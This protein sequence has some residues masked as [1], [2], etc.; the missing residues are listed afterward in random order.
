VGRC[1]APSPWALIAAG[2]GAFA[3]SWIVGF[4]WA[5][6]ILDDAVDR[7]ALAPALGVAVLTVAGIAVDRAGLRLSSDVAM[8]ATLLATVAGYLAASAAGYA[9]VSTRRHPSEPSN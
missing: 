1:R 8:S 6:L 9:R 7:I 2:V 3:L 5:R 4:G